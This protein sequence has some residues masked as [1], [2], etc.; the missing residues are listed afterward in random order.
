MSAGIVAASYVAGAGSYRG[1]VLVDLPVA[2]YRLGEASGTTAVDEIGSFPGMYIGSPTL[3]QVGALPSSADTSVLFGSGKYVNLGNVL[4]LVG[5]SFAMEMWYRISAAQISASAAWS[6]LLTKG[7]NNTGANEYRIARNSSSTTAFQVVVG[8]GV[9]ASLPLNANDAW[10]HVVASF[11]T[12]DSTLRTYSDG[13]ASATAAGS[14]PQANSYETRIAH[15]AQQTARYW[16]GYVD[17]VA[18]YDHALSAARVAAHYA[19]R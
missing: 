16:L 19:A 3:G 15:N 8:T 5:S 12:A 2:Y 6:A 7:D 18:I 11:S 13:V 14:G 10:H 1:E 17:E 4:G 9:V